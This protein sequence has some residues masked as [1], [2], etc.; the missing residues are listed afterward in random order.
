M[1]DGMG[2]LDRFAL[3]GRT[4]LVTGAGQGFGEAFDHALTEAGADVAV[5]D[6][7]VETAHAVAARV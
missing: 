3:H 5:V 1:R 2:I 7:N 4:A 6:L